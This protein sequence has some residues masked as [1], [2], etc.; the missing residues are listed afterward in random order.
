MC[1]RQKKKSLTKMCMS[2]A[3]ALFFCELLHTVDV[4]MQ[5]YLCFYEVSMVK[6]IV[7]AW[8]RSDGVGVLR[9]EALV[10]NH[11]CKV[12]MCSPVCAASRASMVQGN[13]RIVCCIPGRSKFLAVGGFHSWHCGCLFLSG[14]KME[15]IPISM[16]RARACLMCREPTRKK[17]INV[18]IWCWK[19]D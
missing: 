8:S 3:Q 4:M 1:C 12:Y 15:T 2:F 17:T 10:A 14:V 13:R 9:H 19:T 18:V 16:C 5:G 6:I 11:R 7:W